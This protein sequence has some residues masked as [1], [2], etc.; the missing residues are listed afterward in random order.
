[1]KVFGTFLFSFLILFVEMGFLI[2]PI[3]WAFDISII[4][5]DLENTGSRAAV[6]FVLWA[7]AIVI[8]HF[9]QNLTL[10]ADRSELYLSK[11]L[12]H[13]VNGSMP[14]VSGNSNDHQL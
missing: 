6:G 2:F 5:S 11:A 14:R 4:P 10:C 3:E 9:Y 8:A 1:M 13:G 7:N 12:E